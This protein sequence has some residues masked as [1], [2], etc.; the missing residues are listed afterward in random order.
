[1]S[2]PRSH[3]WA[4]L[5]ARWARLRDDGAVTAEYAVT[6]VAACGFAGILYEILKSDTVVNLI[7]KVITKGLSWLL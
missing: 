6:T 2:T 3:H 4:A 7:V 1:M 5:G